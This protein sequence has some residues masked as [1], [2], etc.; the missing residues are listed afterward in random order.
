MQINKVTRKTQVNEGPQVQCSL[1]ILFQSILILL[2]YSYPCTLKPPFTTRKTSYSD[3]MLYTKKQRGQLIFLTKKKKGYEFNMGTLQRELLSSRY[4][5][6]QD[7]PTRNYCHQILV[8]SW[9]PYNQDKRY[10]IGRENHQ[11]IFW[12]QLLE[13]I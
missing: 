7:N 11:Y 1:R 6:R 9:E 12:H 13:P 2:S 8:L 4:R 3:D 5:V 10:K